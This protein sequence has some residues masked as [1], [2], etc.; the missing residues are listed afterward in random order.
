MKKGF[1]LVETLVAVSILTL[2][3]AGPL[4]V[5]SLAISESQYARNQITAS[6][7]A[8]DA[9][10]SIRNIRDANFIIG[11]DWLL[12]L[13]VC[14][15]TANP[16]VHCMLSSKDL[17]LAVS[18]CLSGSPCPNLKYSKITGFYSYDTGDPDSIFTRDIKIKKIDDTNVL[19]TVIMSWTEKAGPKTY[20]LKSYLNKLQ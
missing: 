9:V 18:S 20:V 2:A 11:N 4:A 7:L 14:D 8:E 12:D 1:T 19:I 3:I 5:S 16:A 13:A 15:A 17:P 10:E 6:Y